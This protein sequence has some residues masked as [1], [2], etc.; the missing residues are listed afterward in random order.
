MNSRN[1]DRPV[2][3]FV[4]V[5][6]ARE[7]PERL[8]KLENQPDTGP[9]IEEWGD[10]EDVNDDPADGVPGEKEDIYARGVTIRPSG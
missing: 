5:D 2:R 7:K 3:P 6:Q 8:E 4:D 1:N 10:D 9:V